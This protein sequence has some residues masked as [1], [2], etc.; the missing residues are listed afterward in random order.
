VPSASTSQV[1]DYILER[2]VS[3]VGTREFDPDDVTDDFDLL[4]D[5][6]FDSLGFVELLTALEDRFGGEIDL[7]G[8]DPSTVT[9][10]KALSE[11]VAAN[12]T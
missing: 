7:S 6:G 11:H 3:G 2:L 9:M 10:L 1:R 12:L 4:T 5:A 8:A